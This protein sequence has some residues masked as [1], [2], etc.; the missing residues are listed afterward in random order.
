MQ[1]P[2]EK[3]GNPVRW[4][5]EGSEL[6]AR[7]SILRY[8]QQNAADRKADYDELLEALTD[9]TKPSSDDDEE[10][11]LPFALQEGVNTRLAAIM[12]KQTERGQTVEKT[13]TEAAQAVY[14]ANSRMMDVEIRTTSSAAMGG[15]IKRESIGG[16]TAPKGAYESFKGTWAG[17]LMSPFL[18]VI[19]GLFK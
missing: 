19:E 12:K 15:D 4:K 1:G 6:L 10:V 16:G 5:R 3:G 13:R 8:A 11:A 17:K 14:K 18:S 2:P 7:E 9:K